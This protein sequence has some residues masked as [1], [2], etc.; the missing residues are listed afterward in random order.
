[1]TRNCRCD[2]TRVEIARIVVQMGNTRAMSDDFDCNPDSLLVRAQVK[3]NSAL[4]TPR[5]T[6]GIEIIL[7][8][9]YTKVKFL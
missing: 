5:R 9:H 1:M 6:P 4:R 7:Y 8:Y 3:R 2:L